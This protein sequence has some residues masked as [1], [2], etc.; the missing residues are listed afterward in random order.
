MKNLLVLVLGFLLLAA[1]KKGDDGAP[2]KDGNDGNANVVTFTFGAKTVN[3][4]A[5]NFVLN[6]LRKGF[7][8]SSLVLVYY[9]P[10]AEL[11]GAWYPCP[12]LGSGGLYQTRYLL[13]PGAN[14]NQYVLAFRINKP[15][16]SAYVPA[17]E[18]RRFKFVFV[19]AS[20]I[21]PVARSGERDY[22]DYNKAKSLF[23]WQD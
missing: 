12:G 1:C 9:N 2:G 20:K 3:G 4:G 5:E 10:T 8:D 23:G 7:V 17:V 14:V 21:T 19:P 18:F 11:D 6:N 15:D 16:G 13:Y 22:T